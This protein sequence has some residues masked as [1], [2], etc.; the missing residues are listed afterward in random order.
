MRNTFFLIA[1]VFF[2]FILIVSGVSNY[3][4]IFDM[5][6]FKSFHMYGLLGTTLALTIL[7]TFILK[8]L[9]WKGVLTGDPLKF[10]Q[11]KPTKAHVVG[12]LM[13][14]LGWGL[15]GACPGPALAQL[16]FGTLSGLFTVLGVF[17]GVYIYGILQSKKGS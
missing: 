1:G 4:V 15:T 6:L 10:E 11:L 12:G 14:G 9:E 3:D 7:A 2:G 8:K 17:M 13:A 16:G 5:F